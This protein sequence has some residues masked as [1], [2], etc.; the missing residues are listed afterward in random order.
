M[1]KTTPINPY[2]E[3]TDRSR[4]LLMMTKVMPTAITA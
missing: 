1:E 3:P 4:S 2:V